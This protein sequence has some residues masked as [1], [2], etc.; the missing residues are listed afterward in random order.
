MPPEDWAFADYNAGKNVPKMKKFLSENKSVEQ[1][2]EYKENRAIIFNSKLFHA[3][4]T[5]NFNDK[6]EDRRINIT[7]LYD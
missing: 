2:V 7:F 1:V 4:N 5:F 6:Y 3:T